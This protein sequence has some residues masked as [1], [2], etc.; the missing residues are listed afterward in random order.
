MPTSLPHQ[1]SSLLSADL[2]TRAIDASRP[3]LISLSK[4]EHS[5]ESD[6]TNDSSD[7]GSSDK[8]MM[9]A[10]KMGHK[11]MKSKE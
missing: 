9:L 3:A 5:E 2:D 6:S 7:E 1:V 8:T 10:A 4:M 11:L